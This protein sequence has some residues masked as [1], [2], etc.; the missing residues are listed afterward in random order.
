MEAV[1][2]ALL[3]SVGLADG[4]AASS[5]DAG[6]VA[7]MPSSTTL[8]ASATASPSVARSGRRRAAVFS[9][10]LIALATG[11]V[12]LTLAL[13]RT[14]DAATAGNRDAA[15]ARAAPATPSDETGASDV[16]PAAATPDPGPEPLLLEP[17]VSRPKGDHLF[18]R[19]LPIGCPVFVASVE[20]LGVTLEPVK[21]ELRA[22]H[23]VRLLGTTRLRQD[24]DVLR[25]VAAVADEKHR[26][27]TT[28]LAVPLRKGSYVVLVGLPPH[29]NASPDARAATLKEMEDDSLHGPTIDANFD[30]VTGRIYL[31][32]VDGRE[33]LVQIWQPRGAP[34]EEVAGL[35]PTEESYWFDDVALEELLT[36]NVPT[37]DVK[38]IVSLLHRGGKVVYRQDAEHRLLL[39]SDKE[40]GKLTNVVRFNG[41]LLAKLNTPD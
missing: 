17:A 26:R 1:R 16:A 8:D 33:E 29:T 24:G 4:R 32:D 9:A 36:L 18:V 30:S 34:L 23:L 31:I 19:S 27:G 2:A 12:A 28:P 20:D 39:Q 38:P 6:L 37:A 11:A 40:L 41:K 10:T 25:R 13:G 35:Y 22:P 15:V 7:T 3:T 5:S 14:D 21:E